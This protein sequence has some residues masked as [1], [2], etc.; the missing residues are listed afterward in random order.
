MKE[1]YVS[2]STDPVAKESEEKIV[3][4][5]KK[6]LSSGADFLHCDIMDGKFVERKT[7]DEKIVEK[8]N[9][10]CLIPLDVHLMVEKPEKQIERYKKAGA[11]FLTVH[12]ESFKN[13]KKLIN[14][15]KLIREKEML[16]GV[17]FK[18]ETSVLEI[19]KVLP[20]CDIVLVMSV[21]PGKSGQEFLKETFQKIKELN[22]IKKQLKLNFKIEVDGGINP[23]ISKKLFEKGADIIVSGN[24]FKKEKNK[25]NA[26]KLLK[27]N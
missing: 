23:E 26:I 8:I 14:C 10:N 25:K 22:S 3:D 13:E 20:F 15:L 27:N 21:E 1:K 11:N 17:S 19:Q 18:P 12:F 7:F 6:V 24:Y 9:R 5:A 16:S 2:I 4:Y